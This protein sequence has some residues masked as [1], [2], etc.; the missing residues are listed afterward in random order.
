VT[1][2]HDNPAGR[3]HILLTAFRQ[4][5]GQHKI[6]ITWAGLLNTPQDAPELFVRLAQV[7]SLPKDIAEEIGRLDRGAEFDFDMTMR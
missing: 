5:S 3:L 7:Y 2:Y 1:V 4:S 6:G